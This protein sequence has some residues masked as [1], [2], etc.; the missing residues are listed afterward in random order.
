MNKNQA[1]IYVLDTVHVH[2]LL[3][4]NMYMSVHRIHSNDLSLALECGEYS[5]NRVAE[6]LRR[7]SDVRVRSINEDCNFYFCSQNF[8]NSEI[9]KWQSRRL[10]LGVWR[11][12][13]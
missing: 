8:T 13:R 5:R 9:R 6:K 7:L 2:P 4:V 12:M 11:L 1:F 10:A 3:E